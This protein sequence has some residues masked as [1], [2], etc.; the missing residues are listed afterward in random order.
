ME[1][2]DKTV[3]ISENKFLIIPKGVEHRPVAENELSIMLLEPG[4]TVNTGNIKSELT[5]ALSV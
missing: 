2:R 4:S 1:F 5:L 3:D